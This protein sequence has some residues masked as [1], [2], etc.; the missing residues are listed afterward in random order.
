VIKSLCLIIA[1]AP[2]TALGF[3]YHPSRIDGLRISNPT[4]GF[5][6]YSLLIS[7]D[8]KTAKVFHDQTPTTAGPG[9]GAWNMATSLDKWPVGVH[10]YEVMVFDKGDRAVSV[11][12]VLFI[13]RR[14]TFTALNTRDM[15]M[16][17]YM[18]DLVQSFYFTDDY[19][20]VRRQVR[21]IGSRYVGEISWTVPA[22]HASGI[23]DLLP[24]TLKE[25][26]V[27][28]EVGKEGDE[29]LLERD[30]TRIS[31]S[32]DTGTSAIRVDR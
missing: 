27:V 20:S 10:T 31:S 24:G 4:V 7:D 15:L 1:L 11:A 6:G 9:V 2:A 22:L 32:L 14:F 26:F 28:T 5:H 16:A 19:A 13:N 17:R 25:I 18:N 12:V 8:F 29:A 23:I 30:I 3:S 21:Q